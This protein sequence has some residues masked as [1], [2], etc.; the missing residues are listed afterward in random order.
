MSNS[1]ISDWFYQYSNDVYQFLIYYLG[2][3]DVEDLVQEVFI[4]AIKNEDSFRENST[5]KT[6][7]FSIARNV[8]IDEIRRK[9]RGRIKQLLL[10][11]K[12]RPFD[13][14]T[15]EKVLELNETNQQLFQAIQKLNRNYRDV[16]VLRGIKELSIKETAEILNWKE[17]KV[18]LSYH[19]AI[20]ALQNDKGRFM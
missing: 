13:D 17:E 19:R 3:V 4:R 12:Q 10:K 20:K 16:I 15:P 11:E 9:Q 18:R 6:W 2:S 5:P 1:R 7:L 14:Q 8:A